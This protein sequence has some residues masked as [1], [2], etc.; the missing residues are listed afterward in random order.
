M[1]AQTTSKA[2]RVIY[3]AYYSRCLYGIVTI[4]EVNCRTIDVR[5]TCVYVVLGAGRIWE[6]YNRQA[7]EVEILISFL[8]ENLLRIS[9]C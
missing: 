8:I 4:I 5:Q 9:Y 2:R 7:D 6:D 3:R 1:H